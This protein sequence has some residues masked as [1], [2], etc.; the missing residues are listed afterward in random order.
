MY[1]D[2]SVSG[3][4]HI[5]QRLVL[6][7]QLRDYRGQSRALCNIGNCLRAQGQLG[8]ACVYYLKV[9]ILFILVASLVSFGPDEHCSGNCVGNNS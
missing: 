3:H 8:E 1:F 7:Y 2:A 4:Y 5:L 6:T 9:S